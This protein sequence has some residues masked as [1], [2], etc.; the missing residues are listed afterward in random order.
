MTGFLHGK[1]WTH[2]VWKMNLKSMYVMDPYHVLDSSTALVF[3]L[4]CVLL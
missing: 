2:S 1:S 4:S 3:G